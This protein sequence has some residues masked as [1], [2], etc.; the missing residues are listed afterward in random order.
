MHA[1]L[2]FAMVTLVVIAAAVLPIQGAVA[3]DPPQLQ[4]LIPGA[5]QLVF[6]GQ[7]PVNVVLVGYE[8]GPGPQQ[9][10][11]AHLQGGLAQNAVTM[12]RQVGSI[13]DGA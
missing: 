7:W 1:R 2:R 12:V 10:D 13:R 4:V 6:G 9:V 11:L 5:P 3:D 8:E